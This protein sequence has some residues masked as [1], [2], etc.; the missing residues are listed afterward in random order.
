MIRLT[1]WEHS[2]LLDFF[3]EREWVA[4]ADKSLWLRTRYPTND[5]P[6]IQ[7]MAVKI[8]PPKTTGPFRLY[9]ATVIPLTWTLAESDEYF[10]RTLTN[11]T[12]Y[13]LRKRYEQFLIDECSLPPQ[14][15]FGAAMCL[16]M[17]INDP[18]A[19]FNEPP[20]Q[21]SLPSVKTPPAGLKEL[22]SNPKTTWL[23]T[24]GSMGGGYVSLEYRY[25]AIIAEISVAHPVH[26][27]FGH[28]LRGTMRPKFGSARS[29]A[30]LIFNLP[31]YTSPHW[32]E[33]RPYREIPYADHSGN[34]EN[35]SSQAGAED[36]E[37][38]AGTAGAGDGRSGEGRSDLPD[39]PEPPSAV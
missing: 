9:T 22:T 24:G 6:V 34:E 26:G 18:D 33:G 19:K 5:D 8:V 37:N 35:T 23:L 12:G 30:E 28:P 36:L 11:W 29:A 31:G 16:T 14:K 2:D 39:E 21:Q 4:N 17:M 27:G 7:E 15:A 25:G 20:A 3:T 38:P 13:A 32:E 1:H 10:L